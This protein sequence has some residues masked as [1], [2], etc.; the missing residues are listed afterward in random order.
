MSQRGGLDHH[1]TRFRRENVLLS[2]T[3]RSEWKLSSFLTSRSVVVLQDNDLCSNK[4]SMLNVCLSA[5]E[6]RSCV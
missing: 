6:D 1:R 5:G 3:P 2:F 4:S